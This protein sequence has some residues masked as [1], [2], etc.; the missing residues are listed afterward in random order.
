VTHYNPGTA[1]P[2]ERIGTILGS[3]L[4]RPLRTTETLMG[5]YGLEEETHPQQTFCHSITDS[6]ITP[7]IDTAL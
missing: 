4:S 3:A 1:L 6:N 7:E 5:V 2:S